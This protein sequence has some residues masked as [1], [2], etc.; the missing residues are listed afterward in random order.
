MQENEKALVAVQ[1]EKGEEKPKSY[2]LRV[3]LAYTMLYRALLLVLP[4]FAV[5]FVITC[6]RAF[7]YNSLF[8][9]VKDLQ[10][11]S[12]F[13]P[14][15]Y[16]TVSYTYREGES[17][18]LS[19]HGCVANVSTGGIEVYSPGGERLLDVPLQLQ[20]PRAAASDKYL[21]AYDFGKTGFTVTNAYARLHSGKTEFPIYG[22]SVADTG[23]IALITSSEQHLSQVLLYDVN[24]NLLQ[25]FG[26]A[27][28]T[29]AVSV[30]NNGRYVAITGIS[31]H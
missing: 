25:R 12:S 19:Y 11:V 6:P 18:T 28:A 10:S 3:S 9:F 20:A 22:A 5:L 24:F 29:T 2:W 8:C 27:S 16:K 31:S 30:S 26:R 21:V 7:S 14:S 23:H 15:E 4:V 13:A 1:P 17:R